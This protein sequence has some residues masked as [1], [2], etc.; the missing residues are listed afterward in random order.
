MAVLGS[1]VEQIRGVSYKPEDLHSNLNANSIMLL[2]A[3]NIRDDMVNFDEV[4]YVDR[5]KVADKQLLKAGDILI[6]TSS[7]SKELVG[8]AAYITEDIEATFGAFCKVVRPRSQCAKYIG[9]FF[10]SPIYRER[11]ANVAGGANINNIRNEH[12]D[13]LTIPLPAL[14]EQESIA[15]LLDSVTALISLR[16][17]Q[18]AKLDELVKSRFVEMFGDLA[19]PACNWPQL[20]LA[21]ACVDPDDIKCGPFGTQLSKDEY[22][23]AGVAVWEI[24]QIN[25]HFSTQPTHYLTEEKAQQLDAY[26]LKPGDIA[27]SRKGNVGKCSIFPSGFKAGIIHSDVLRIRVDASRVSPIFM[28]HQLHYSGAVQHQIEL[29]SS[30]AIMSGIN[31]TK[32]KQIFV[33]IPPL[34]LQTQF[35]AFVEQTEKSK[36]TIQYSLAKLE[37]LKK[38]LMQMYFG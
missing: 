6:C 9:H 21:E 20:R 10:C 4:V 29:V 2:R 13:E 33:H 31:V 19:N 18:I 14:A 24:P 1:L 7:G 34:E 35:A 11:I 30:G 32:L 8:K 22:K 38:S 37:T 12:I 27:M 15:A 28:M 3:N 36:L 26:S 25:S 16:K 5:K 23:D 17:L